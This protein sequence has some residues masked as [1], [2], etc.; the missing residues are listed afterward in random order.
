MSTHRPRSPSCTLN[1]VQIQRL[2]NATSPKRCSS[3]RH[4][5]DNVAHRAA[6]CVSNPTVNRGESVLHR[7]AWASILSPT[8]CGARLDEIRAHWRHNNERNHVSGILLVAGNHFLGI[9]EGDERDL[10]DLWLRL[11]RDD[12]HRDLIRIE[13]AACGAR[14]FPSWTLAYVKSKA[15]RPQIESLRRRHAP[16]APTWNEIVDTASSRADSM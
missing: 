13:A 14:Q 6:F 16:I 1:P 4:R 9:L 8:F 11:E 10:G 5:T 3:V 12:R 2:T 7:I 15:V